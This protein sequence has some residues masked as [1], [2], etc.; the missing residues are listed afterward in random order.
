MLNVLWPSL[1][2][3]AY[4]YAIYTGNIENINNAIFE[5]TR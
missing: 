3:V 4:I 1:I 5:Y 2:L